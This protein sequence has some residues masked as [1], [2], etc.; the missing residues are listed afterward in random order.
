MVGEQFITTVKEIRAKLDATKQ[1]AGSCSDQIKQLEVRVQKVQRAKKPADKLLRYLVWLAIGMCTHNRE[2]LFICF[3][4]LFV[5]FYLRIIFRINVNV[6][7]RQFKEVSNVNGTKC[8][9][10]GNEITQRKTVASCQ[11]PILHS[12]YPYYSRF[13]PRPH[14]RH[15]R[16]GFRRTLIKFRNSST[17]RINNKHN[18]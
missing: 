1:A 16:R 5:F 10:F 17:N 18:A 15:S 8:F 13:T 11:D 4:V 2:L 3:S 12:T 6:P 7:R 14:P 9:C